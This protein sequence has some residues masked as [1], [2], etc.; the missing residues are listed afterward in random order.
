MEANVL[1]FVLVTLA[2]V[3]AI[4]GI[5]WYKYTKS[6]EIK[7]ISPEQQPKLDAPQGRQ[8]DSAKV[9]RVLKSF[10]SRNGYE[11]IQPGKIAYQTKVSDFD[12][13]VVGSFGVLAVRSMGYYGQVY[14]NTKEEK[15]AQ[16]TA[17]GRVEFAN[18]INQAE[19]DARLV[20]EVL[21]ENKIKSVPV[22]AVCVFPNK[23]TELMV[24]RSTPVYRL[25]EFSA[26][27]LKDHYTENKKVDIDAVAKALRAAVEK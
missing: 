26:H 8:E 4:V 5:N 20:R 13:L 6:K 24:P 25:K 17:K 15:W 1:E 12:A 18:P 14:G 21:F 27:L 22:E 16:T 2:I 9:M 23:A 10:A 7:E 19:A 3:A 11:L